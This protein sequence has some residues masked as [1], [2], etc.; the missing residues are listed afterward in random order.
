MSMNLLHIR[1]FVAGV[2]TMAMMAWS[3][4]AADGQLR[5]VSSPEAGWPQF[6]GPSRDGVSRETGLL[7]SWPE[8]GPKR[9][10]EVQGLGRGYSSPIL[11]GSRVFVTGDVGDHLK[12]SALDLSGRSIWSVTNGAA[13]KDPYPGARSTVTFF[14]GRLFHMNAHGRLVCLDP[15]NG[16]E[17]WSIDVLQKF[18]GENITWGLSECLAV[19]E[20]GVYVTAGGKKALVAALSTQDGSV[21]WRTPGYQD[22]AAGGKWE[23]AS[24]VS[25]ILVEQGGKRWLVG[26]SL[27]NLFC[28]DAR[29]G[30][31]QWMEKRPTTYSVLAMPPVV[32]GNGIFTTAPHGKGGHWFKLSV[33]GGKSRAEEGW[34]TRLDTCQGGV[35][36]WD[37]KIIGAHYSS[38]KGWVALDAKSGEVL[39]DM[40]DR[41]KGSALAADGRVYAY[42]EDGWVLLLESGKS[43]FEIRG[44][45][46]FA[47]ASAMDAW[48]HPVLLDGRLYLRYHDRL[49]CFDVKAK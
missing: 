30:A 33:E 45:F 22:A 19:D 32:V 44:R 10:W 29:T 40:A 42:S 2:W 49:A 9:I 20:H 21:L 3:V 14:G 41:V 43:G 15:A 1:T 5:W 12:I 34:Q 46:R 13:W 4:Q 8:G 38:R 47:E 37:G 7:Q 26:S 16:R 25:P 39:Y 11:V 27:K 24:Y 23:S 31:L 28:V 35:V 17:H 36:V 48:A 6:R 18:E